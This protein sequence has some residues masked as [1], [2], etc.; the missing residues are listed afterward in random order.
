MRWAIKVIWQNGRED[1]VMAGDHVAT[2]SKFQAK[3]QVEFLKVGMDEDVQ[4]INVV[5]APKP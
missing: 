2:Y 4:S 1:Y 5:P 3:D